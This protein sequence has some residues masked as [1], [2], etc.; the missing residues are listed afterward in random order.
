MKAQYIAD[1]G[2]KPFVEGLMKRCPV[3]AP[4]AKRSSFVFSE[5]SDAAELRLDY[6]TTILPP[7]KVFFPTEQELVTFSKDGFEGCINPKEQVLFGVHPHDIIGLDMSDSFYASN[8]ADE[9]YLAY[10]AATIIVGSSVQNHYKHAFFGSVCKGR[11]PKG[12]D[13]FLTRVDGGYVVEVLTEKGESLLAAGE[14]VEATDAQVQESQAVNAAALEGCPEALNNSAD[15]IQTKVREAFSS[16]VWETL[17]DDCFSCGSCNTVCPTCYC[18]D[19]QD[20]WALDGTSGSRYRTW[21]ACLT[22]EFSE[23]SVQGGTENF[24]EKR[25]ER[26]RH[27]FMRKA[28]YLNEQLGGPACVGCGR[29]SGACT[30]AIANPTTVIN[31]IMEQ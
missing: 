31:S 4:V 2:L 1:D 15:E 24:R 13:L 30:A 11:D 7:K 23:V 6:D 27:R 25:A 9:N 5:L 14:F 10:R 28:V 21:D 29:C 18:F 17:S 16:D 22:C 8:K 3:I 12:H 19:V 20:K 26:Y